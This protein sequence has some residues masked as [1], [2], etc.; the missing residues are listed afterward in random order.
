MISEFGLTSVFFS[1]G[2]NYNHY[3]CAFFSPVF[4]CEIILQIRAC[5]FMHTYTGILLHNFFFHPLDQFEIVVLSCYWSGLMMPV[6]PAVITNLTVILLLNVFFFRLLFAAIFDRGTFNVWEFFLCAIY[7]LV[8]SILRSNTSLKRNQYFALFFFLFCYIF[9]ANMVGLIPYSFTA[10]SSFVITFFLAL[11][12]FIGIN[13]LSVFK[14]KWTTSN[15]FL[16]GGVPLAIAPFLILI[17]MVSY[18]AKVF[19]LSIRLFANMMS[20]HALLKIL[21]GFAWDL[22]T[23]GYFFIFVAF[24]PW[25]IVTI[26]LFLEALIAF[27]QAYVFTVLVTIY[28]NDALVQH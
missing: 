8:K 1:H 14:N 21:I 12:Y 18:F 4:L 22:L 26:I 20:G 23:K 11:S 28:V 19:S 2:H 7:D 27:L 5:F 13:I 16:P 17:E 15:L 9:T 25:V 24:F 10:T 6:G 3:S